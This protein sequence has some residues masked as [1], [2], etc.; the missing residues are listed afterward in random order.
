MGDEIFAHELADFHKWGAASPEN[1][2]VDSIRGSNF[3]RLDIREHGL[4]CFS[5][6]SDCL[7]F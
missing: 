5:R 1:F 6:G 4:I 2:L 3:Q 7:R